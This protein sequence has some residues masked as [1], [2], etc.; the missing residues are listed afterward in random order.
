MPKKGSDKLSCL[1]HDIFHCLHRK[2]V[3]MQRPGAILTT[4]P[5]PPPHVEF[6]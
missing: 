6:F 5:P 3:L 4:P 2:K 1:A